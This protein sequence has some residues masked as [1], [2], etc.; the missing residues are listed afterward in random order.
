MYHIAVNC[1]HLKDT[2]ILKSK[3]DNFY[4]R[5]LT[6][7]VWTGGKPDLPIQDTT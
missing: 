5:Y 2:L 4:L 7:D 1:F 6:G 3:E